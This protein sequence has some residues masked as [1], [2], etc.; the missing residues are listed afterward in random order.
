MTEDK[1]QRVAQ[2]INREEGCW[3]LEQIRDKFT[4]ET[5]KKIERIPICLEG[6][7]DKLVWLPSQDGQYS[8]KS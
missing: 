2:I 4:E 7:K 8:I 1:V 6:G 5:T 3:D